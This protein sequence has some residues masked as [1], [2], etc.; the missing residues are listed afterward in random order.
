MDKISETI[1]ATVWPVDMVTIG[2]L[3]TG[4]L[5]QAATSGGLDVE[6]LHL[7]KPASN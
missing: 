3:V 4:W 5:L 7:V 2:E 1:V 6:A